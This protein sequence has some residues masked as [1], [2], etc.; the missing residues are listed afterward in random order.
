MGSLSGS[1][2]RETLNVMTTALTKRLIFL[3]FIPFS[4]GALGCDPGGKSSDSSSNEFAYE[5]F[6]GG[7]TTGKHIFPSHD[8]FCDGLKNHALNNFCAKDYRREVFQLNCSGHIWE[9]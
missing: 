7:C 6:V 4:I 3:A 5:Y 2:I 8:A 9:D 1:S